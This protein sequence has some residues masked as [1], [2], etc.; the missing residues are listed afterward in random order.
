MSPQ[1]NILRHTCPFKPPN[2]PNLHP[3]GGHRGNRKEGVKG[4]DLKYKGEQ[5]YFFLFFSFLISVKMKQKDLIT[6][7][8]RWDDSPF[9]MELAEDEVL[10]RRTSSSSLRFSFKDKFRHIR[11]QE[12]YQNKI[13]KKI[14][15]WF[16]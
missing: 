14:C 4:D 13:L 9:E 5:L 10:S 2:D 16:T 11:Q 12:E 8:K 15:N 1:G 7:Y 3:K 6:N